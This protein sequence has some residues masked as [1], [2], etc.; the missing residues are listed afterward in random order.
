MPTSFSPYVV[1]I[2]TDILN[3]RAGAGTFYKITA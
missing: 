3:V 2:D 1:Q